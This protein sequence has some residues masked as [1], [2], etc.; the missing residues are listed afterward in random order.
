[1]FGTVKSLAEFRLAGC[2]DGRMD[3]RS[4]GNRIVRN[5][6][7]KVDS[8]AEA[9]RVCVRFRFSAVIFIL[10]PPQSGVTV[11]LRSPKPTK[12]CFALFVFY[13]YNFYWR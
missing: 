4:H 8:E 13:K 1:M 6:N 5:G 3:G 11:L 2:M 9:E 7:E 10:L 12:P